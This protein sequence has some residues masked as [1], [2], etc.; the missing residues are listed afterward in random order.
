M[1]V[2]AF[3]LVCLYLLAVIFVLCCFLYQHDK[4]MKAKSES[5]EFQPLFASPK[6]MH[7]E[8]AAE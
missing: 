3:F 2:T 8:D 7:D 1:D 6:L 5:G 4:F